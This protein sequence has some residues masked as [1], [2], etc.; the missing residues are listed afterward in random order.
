MVSLAANAPW[1]AR[2]LDTSMVLGGRERLRVA[3]RRRRSTRRRCCPRSARRRADRSRRRAR[4]AAGP[5]S[6]DS[7]GRRGSSHGSFPVS[8]H[9][10]N[11][12]EAPAVAPIQTRGVWP[13]TPR[14]RAK[15][16]GGLGTSSAWS[17]ANGARRRARRE[18]QPERGARPRA[19]PRSA[20]G[21]SRGRGRAPTAAPRRGRPRRRARAGCTQLPADADVGRHPPLVKAHAAHA[22]VDGRERRRARPRARAGRGPRP[23]RSASAGLRDPLLGSEARVER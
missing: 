7:S 3:A 21:R 14:G 12:S 19:R 23:S 9:Q 15:I 13:T 8:R 6:A 18:A 5:P 20:T 4:A 17:V 16:A 2:S 1:W 11:P 10:K 22:G